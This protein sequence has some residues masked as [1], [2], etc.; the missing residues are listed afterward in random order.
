MTRHHERE[1]APPVGKT[2][3][4]CVKAVTPASDAYQA[5]AAVAR[6]NEP[7]ILWMPS[8]VANSPIASSRNV[9]VSSAKTASTA[10]LTRVAAIVM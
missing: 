10:P 9:S 5:A 7:P 3:R 2:G 1:S 8:E 4:L 6:P